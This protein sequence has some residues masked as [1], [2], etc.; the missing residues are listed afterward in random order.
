MNDIVSAESSDYY[1][2]Q[3]SWPALF[4]IRHGGRFLDIGCGKGMLGAFLKQRFAAKV[5]GIEI[6][7]EYADEAAKYL[8][9]VLCGNIEEL[10][11]T[12][13]KNQFDHVIF[14]DSLEHLLDPKSALM[15]ARGMLRADG[16]L[17]L[18]IPNVRNFRVTLPLIFLG[19]FEYQD[20][21][22]LDRTHLRFFTRSSITN[23]LQKCGFEVESVKVDLPSNSKVGLLNMLTLGLFRET[24]TSHFFIKACKKNS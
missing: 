15:K 19:R 14:S 1:S 10:N 7:Q 20:E 4:Q 13:Y 9:E 22:L 16:A 17:L 11:L 2:R 5:T 12:A 3:R 18:A 6:F 21:G 8:D 23:L 24:L